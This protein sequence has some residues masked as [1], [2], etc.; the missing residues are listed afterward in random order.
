MFTRKLLNFDNDCNSQIVSNHSAF[1]F[2]KQSILLQIH[3]VA[4]TY[5]LCIFLS[6]SQLGYIA[7][8]FMFWIFLVSNLDSFV[9]TSIIYINS[10]IAASRC[11]Q[12]LNVRTIFFIWMQSYYTSIILMH[13]LHTH[14]EII[15]KA[16]V[17]TEC[18]C[19]DKN[20][21]CDRNIFRKTI[22]INGA[23]RRI[24]SAWRSST[25]KN[26]SYNNIPDCIWKRIVPSYVIRFSSPS[27]CEVC[28]CASCNIFSLLGR[29]SGTVIQFCF[30]INS[31]YE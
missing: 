23:S 3:S 17:Q 29:Q 16:S 20:F 25:P 24:T 22:T 28:S 9:P 30:F 11:K 13:R 18:E 8:T 10:T 4:S 19:Y 15:R 31:S 2:S 12:I 27:K 14:A 26:Y 5:T 7:S 21:R 6:L 1:T